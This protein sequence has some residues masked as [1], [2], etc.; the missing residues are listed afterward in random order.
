MTHGQHNTKIRRS[1][2]SQF[3]EQE[4]ASEYPNAPKTEETKRIIT[5]KETSQTADTFWPWNSQELSLKEDSWKIVKL[6]VPKKVQK[7]S[8]QVCFWEA[9]MTVALLIMA[10]WMQSLPVGKIPE[11]IDGNH[12]PSFEMI[13]P[14]S[15]L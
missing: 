3:P 13:K 9:L 15:Q 2:V 7:P 12:L 4:N 5:I 11:M 10:L 8:R 1:P 6:S 14:Q